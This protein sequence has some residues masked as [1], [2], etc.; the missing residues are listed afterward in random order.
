MND[1][2]PEEPPLLAE[3]A[4]PSRWPWFLAAGC[5]IVVFIALLLL[6]R[7]TKPQE[8]TALADLPKAA[9]AAGPGNAGA[10]GLPA[11][12]SKPRFRIEPGLT[13]TE[14]VSNKVAQ[15]TRSRR[16]LAHD[17]AAQFKLPIPEEFERFFDA[18]EAGRF[19]EMN[20]IFQS[21]RQQ[22]E[23]GASKAWYGPH[24]RAIVETQ[25]A[26]EAAHGW[27]AQ[28]LLDYGEVVLG[29]LRPGMVYVGGN[30]AGCFIPT[31]LNETSSGERHVVLT[32]NALADG[33]Y[34]DYLG[35]LYRDQ[36][37]T[38]TKEDSQRVFQEYL[39]DA[40]KRYRHDQE[41]P[42]EP[43]QVRPGE[44]IRVTDN[45]TQVSG[46]VAVMTINENLLRTLMEKNPGVSFAMVESFPFKSTYANASPLGPILELGV[47][48]PQR[49]LTAER[50]AQSIA[51]WQATSQELLTDPEAAS[52]P[53]TLKAYSKL[54]TAQAHLF[55]E[56]KFASEAEQAYR[57]ATEI[58]PYSPEAVF[59]YVSLLAGEKRFQ[60]AIPV[61]E[62]SVKAEPDNR[63][64]DQLLRELRKHA[65]RR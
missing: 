11:R 1:R 48:D 61:V 60:E 7:Q 30:D 53:E 40:T 28:K 64:F 36:L 33:T 6:H 56:R 58:C 31:L 63:Q 54:A 41:F 42:N 46:Q 34:L 17:L 57:V 23:S 38:P 39:A 35:F 19:D 16:K 44:D 3:A 10:D 47:Q 32:Q 21:L 12:L 45:K 55:T 4:R 14:V 15:F 50:A 37:T 20:A 59:G 51:Y 49:A 22:R 26:A 65:A 2:I 5:L 29:S 9:P 27:P 25:G 52:S 43:K 8:H 62:R 13:A 18:A 24:W